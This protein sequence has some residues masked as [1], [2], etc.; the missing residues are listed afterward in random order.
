MS[1]PIVNRVI[2]GHAPDVGIDQS[3]ERR[4][5]HLEMEPTPATH[6]DRIR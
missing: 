4:V 1:H 5:L 3:I 2:Q 6:K